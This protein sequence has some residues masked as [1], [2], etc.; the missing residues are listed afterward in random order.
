MTTAALR[1]LIRNSTTQ[2]FVVC[3]DD[4]ATYRVSKPD[5]TLLSTE[6]VLIAAAPG[7]SFAGCSFV[8]CPVSQIARVILTKPRA[9]AKLAR[10]G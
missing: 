8:I 9:Q 3:M 6:S 5:R 4:G 10:V 1:K 7:K 2:P